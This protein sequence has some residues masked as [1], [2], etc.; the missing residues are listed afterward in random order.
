MLKVESVDKF[1]ADLRK[2]TLLYK[3]YKAEESQVK[4]ESGI[5]SRTKDLLLQQ[6]YKLKASIEHIADE[7]GVSGFQEVQSNLEAK[8][9]AKGEADEDKGKTLEEISKVVAELNRQIK[10]Q[11][12]RLAPLIKELR[13]IRQQ[14]QETEIEHTEKKSLFDSATMGIV[15]CVPFLIF[16]DQFLTQNH[17]VSKKE[18]RRRRLNLR[19]RF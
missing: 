1:L 15:K 5:L 4:T 12:A 8:S 2:K 3:K 13:P 19:R 6:E 9:T 16:F 14:F 11:K 18:F 10:D 17:A 7:R